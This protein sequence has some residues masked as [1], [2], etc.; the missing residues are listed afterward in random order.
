MEKHF[1]IIQL[2]L[3]LIANYAIALVMGFQKEEAK[4]ELEKIQQL[5]GPLSVL[6]AVVGEGS[7][8]AYQSYCFGYE[9]ARVAPGDGWEGDL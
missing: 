7:I 6:L 5:L 9:G 2:L 3:L 8:Y 4:P 1:I